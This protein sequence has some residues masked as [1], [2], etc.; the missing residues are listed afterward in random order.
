MKLLITPAF[1][2]TKSQMDKLSETNEIYQITDERKPIRPADI[3]CRIDE[4]RGIVCNSFFQYNDFRNFKGLQFVQLTS[5]GIDRVPVDAMK[6]QG[7]HVFTAGDSY[8]VPM[9]EWAVGKTLEIFKKSFYFYSNQ[10][11]RTWEKNRNI[12]EIEG[13]TAAVIG[14]GNVGRNISKRLKSFGVTI[15]AV[16]LYE[17]EASLFDCFFYIKD[18]KNAVQNADIV[19]LTLPL[20]SETYHIVDESLLS[21]M[22]EDAALINIS[23]GGLIDEKA[24]IRF[25][26]D[27]KFSGVA[28]DV[29]ENEPLNPSSKLWNYERVLLSPHNSF[30]G[31]KNQSRL[32][33]LLLSNMENAN[34]KS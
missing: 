20:K 23:R 31:T 7:I 13:K 15:F 1:R 3:P 30:V 27:G 2:P 22:K 19:Y 4:L 9:A 32:Y 10:K 14:F 26:D 11:R 5:V 8:A 17:S 16:D 21:C 6:L 33:Q 24:L 34:L 29:F 25:L 12:E 18:I 28:L